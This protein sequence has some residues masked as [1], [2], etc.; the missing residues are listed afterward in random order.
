RRCGTRAPAREAALHVLLDDF[1]KLRGN[2]V[3]LEGD[4][5][6][7][8]LID[9]RY[10]PLAGSGEADADVGVLALARAVHHATHHRDGHVLHSDIF[11]APFGHA[12]ADVGLNALGELLEVGARGPP[13]P[14]TRDDHRCEG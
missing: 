13:A 5:L 9:R 6:L 7:A 1:L 14:R 2:V 12:V 10:R 11:F 3:A 8:V 4:G